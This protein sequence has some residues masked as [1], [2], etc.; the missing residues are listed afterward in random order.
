MT[1]HKTERAFPAK[2]LYLIQAGYAAAPLAL[3]KLQQVYAPGDQVVLMGD[4]VMHAAHEAIRSLEKCYVL[5]NE[6]PLLGADFDNIQLINYSEFADL[7]L[8]FSRCISLK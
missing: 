8:K 6:Q 5:D 2:T 1:E 4:A 3:Q 7:C